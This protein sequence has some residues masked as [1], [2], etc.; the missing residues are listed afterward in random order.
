GVDDLGHPEIGG[1]RHERDRL[2]LAEL[3]GCHEET[4]KLAEG[5]AHRPINAR[6]LRNRG[7]RV[8]AETCE[9]V[10]IGKPVDRPLLVCLKHRMVET[11]KS[12]DGEVVLLVQMQFSV[13]S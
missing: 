5:V 9:I 13:D 10:R 4:T 11:L 8:G 3:V 6:M 7:L 2:I 12:R 1:Y